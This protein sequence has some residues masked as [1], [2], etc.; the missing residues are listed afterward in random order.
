MN[1]K[2]IKK[3][4]KANEDEFE[5]DGSEDEYENIDISEYVQDGDDEVGDYKLR[6]DNYPEQDD[7]KDNS[8]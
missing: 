2:M 7:N 5:M 6:D 1:L 4:L 8:S 3:N